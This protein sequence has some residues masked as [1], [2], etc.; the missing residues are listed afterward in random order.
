MYS[1]NN[2]EEF[3][4]NMLLL[5]NKMSLVNENDTIF[6]EVKLSQSINNN[7]NNNLLLLSTYTFIIL[8]DLNLLT[9]NKYNFILS[10]DNK[11][12]NLYYFINLIN[13]LLQYVYIYL[14]RIFNI[15][16]LKI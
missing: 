14:Y 9:Y 4:S 16:H 3:S 5:L 10:N 2:D 7:N 11:N 8:P 1:A 6:F 13:E 12:K 15:I